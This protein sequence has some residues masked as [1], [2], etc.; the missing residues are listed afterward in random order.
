[1]AYKQELW[2]EAKRKCHIGDE[3][4]RMANFLWKLGNGTA[5]QKHDKKYPK[6]KREVESPCER[7]DTRY[8]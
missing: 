8:V 1:M 4:I 5:T 6:Q 3:E 7:L 2:D